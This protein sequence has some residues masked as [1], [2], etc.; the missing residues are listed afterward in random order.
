MLKH[1]LKNN[2][3]ILNAFQSAYPTHLFT[4]RDYKGWYNKIHEIYLRCIT[5][6]LCIACS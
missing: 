2:D 4:W 1:I 5:G 6:S 3:V